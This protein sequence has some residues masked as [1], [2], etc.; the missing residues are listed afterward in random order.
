MAF[1]GI[2]LKL[3]DRWLATAYARRG[4]EPMQLNALLVSRDQGRTW[5]YLSTIADASILPTPPRKWA[6]GPSE[7]ALVRL[8]DGELMA[9]FRVGNG[10]TGTCAGLQ[11]GWWDDMVPSRRDPGLQRGAQHGS[12]PRRH[13]RPLH[14]PARNIALVLYRREGTP[15]AGGGRGETPQPPRPR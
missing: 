6:G 15:V 13:H 3:E 5:R 7:T 10:R 12:H 1:D 8:A 2:A 14:G 11:Q 9:V 4:D